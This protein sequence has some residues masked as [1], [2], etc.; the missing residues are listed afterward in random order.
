LQDLL[1]KY[2]LISKSELAKA[3]G[4][5]PLEEYALR[6]LGHD[7]ML[8]SGAVIGKLP[9]VE[10]CISLRKDVE[11]EIG[12][13]QLSTCPEEP[14][15][16]ASIDRPPPASPVV[17]R[18]LFE[19][20]FGTLK[21]QVE[22]ALASPT[23]SKLRL[24][25]V[26]SVKMLTTFVNN[27]QPHDLVSA[28]DTFCAAKTADNLLEGVHLIVTAL[29][30]LLRMY[31][32]SALTDFSLA[33]LVADGEL[34]HVKETRDLLACEERLML[35][36]E[37]LH[38]LPNEWQSAYGSYHIEAHLMYGPKSYGMRASG[39]SYLEERITSAGGKQ[40]KQ[41]MHG[42]V[43]FGFWVGIGCFGFPI[44]LHS[45][46]HYLPLS[47]SSTPTFHHFHENVRSA[48]SYEPLQHPHSP[49]TLLVE[50]QS[51]S[52]T[53]STLPTNPYA[54]PAPPSHSSIMRAICCRVAYY[55]LSR[56]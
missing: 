38:N 48:S 8:E 11:L 21:S 7:E 36:V 47:S 50:C 35:S 22:K 1:I 30:R 26:Q 23:D 24:G 3:G 51:P 19:N 5:I 55:S 18:E 9:Y 52:R 54:S 49:L 37:S 44:P 10:R 46:T 33:P 31:S 41:Q 45:I 4:T 53:R 6:V 13:V 28:A 39:M 17:T 14:R 2:R 15:I 16:L 34:E 43:P 56:P 12:R 27:T 32:R 42:L 20:V 40:Q 25:V 29:H